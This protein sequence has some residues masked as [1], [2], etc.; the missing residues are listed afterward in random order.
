[1]DTLRDPRWPGRKET[2]SAQG[3]PVEP[4]QAED[5][6]PWFFRPIP[7]RHETAEIG[8]VVIPPDAALPLDR[9]GIP[10]QSVDHASE[11]LRDH[12]SDGCADG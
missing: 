1:M 11:D 10:G 7:N 2:R 6:G 4:P 9:Q 12:E 5:R 8:L 3:A